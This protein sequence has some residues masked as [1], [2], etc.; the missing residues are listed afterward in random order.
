MLPREMLSCIFEYLNVDALKVCASSALYIRDIILN[1]LISS[2]FEQGKETPLNKQVLNKLFHQHIWFQSLPYKPVISS[3]N[4]LT[5]TFGTS[6]LSLNLQSLH[7]K[8]LPNIIIESGFFKQ[9]ASLPPA[10]PR[11]LIAENVRELTLSYDGANK[12]SDWTLDLSNCMHRIQ[13]HVTH[14]CRAFPNVQRLILIHCAV[15]LAFVPA[16]NGGNK[17]ELLFP[18]L[19]HFYALQETHSLP[20]YVTAEPVIAFVKAYGHQLQSVIVNGVVGLSKASEAKAKLLPLLT[21]TKIT[22]ELTISYGYD[23]DKMTSIYFTNSKKYKQ[24]VPEE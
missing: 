15:P 13:V 16:K 7:S 6:L 11:L 1:D 20:N 18:K 4:E 12:D 14:M 17:E 23:L 24:N 8:V 22:Q 3:L 2:Y 21:N 9:T 19:T 10:P 5:P